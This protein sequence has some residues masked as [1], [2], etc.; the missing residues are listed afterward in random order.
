MLLHLQ[1]ASSVPP[2]GVLDL[3][4]VRTRLSRASCQVDLVGGYGACVTTHVLGLSN[5]QTSFLCNLKYDPPRWVL[6]S[7]HATAG[8]G[9][10]ILA[11]VLNQQDIVVLIDHHGGN[12]H[13][14]SLAP[15]RASAPS[16]GVASPHSTLLR[17]PRSLTIY[18]LPLA[19]VCIRSAYMRQ[20][21]GC[22]F[23]MALSIYSAGV[24][25]SR[26]WWGRYVS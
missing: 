14:K 23:W 8:Q 5:M 21:R 17:L 15:L 7:H 3:P 19:T 20:R 9:P 11:V 4:V 6:L 2:N 16:T 24:R 12:S 10:L 26:D 1:G 13:I 22:H 25:A 18:R